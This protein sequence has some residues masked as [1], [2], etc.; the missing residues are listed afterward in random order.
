[1]LTGATGFIGSH[2]AE[3]L[4]RANFRVH[5]WIRRTNRYIAWS[6]AA[7]AKIYAA[8]AGGRA[9]LRES[10]QGADTV[11]HCA[12]ATK[13]INMKYYFEANVALTQQILSLIHA[14]Q[15]FVFVSSLAAAG[16]SGIDTPL[17]E[18]CAPRPISRYGMSKLLS[19]RCAEEWGSANDNNFVIL[20]PCVVYGP[21]E[22][23]LYNYFKWVKRGLFPLVNHGRGR[24]SVIHVDD[25]VNAVLAAAERSP[26]GETYFVSNDHGASLLDLGHAIQAALSKGHMTKLEL[27]A[28]LLDAVAGVLDGAAGITGKPA[29]LSREK[30]LE[31]KQPAWLCSNGKIRQKVGWEPIISL[32]D[33]IK[34]TVDWYRRERWL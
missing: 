5:L 6:E 9:S 26:G 28:C 14:P 10:L 25:L 16:P 3:R 31:M 17:D 21:R 13:A 7:G 32:E 8:G 1:M 19:E 30:V 29:L 18:H 33:G 11:I 2:I 22:K 20:R 4:L 24:I 12:G 34:D 15:R 27:P 23:D